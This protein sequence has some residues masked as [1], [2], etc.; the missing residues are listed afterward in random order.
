MISFLLS[1]SGRVGRG[2]W[3]L[4][5]LVAA[6]T[7][8]GGC[9]AILGTTGN[10]T[11]MFLA[12]LAMVLGCWCNIVVSIKRYHDRNKSGWWYFV[13]MIPLVGG[14][15]QLIELGFC[16][17]D[18]GENN[19]GLPGGNGGNKKVRDDG[20]A[21]VSSKFA[22]IDDAYFANYAANQAKLAQAASAPRMAPTTAN[23]A[24]VFGKRI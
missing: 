6:V 1:P 5:Q 3:W 16:S 19:Y 21:E 24:P 7:I 17:G 2:M 14:L 9:L 20:G 18:D 15:W 13:I 8:G 4:S 10:S 23:G 12:G 22:K 11:A